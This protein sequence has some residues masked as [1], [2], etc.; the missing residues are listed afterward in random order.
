LVPII[1]LEVLGGCWVYRVHCCL[2]A[3]CELD[4]DDTMVLT[5]EHSE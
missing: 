2:V 1:L 5:S 3:W 4:V